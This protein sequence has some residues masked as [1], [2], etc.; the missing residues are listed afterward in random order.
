MTLNDPKTSYLTLAMGPKVFQNIWT[1]DI[2]PKWP[3]MNLTF[4]QIIPIAPPDGGKGHDGSE[5]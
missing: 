4:G 3:W 2:W 1:Q 5:A